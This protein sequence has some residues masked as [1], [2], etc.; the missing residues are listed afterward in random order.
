MYIVHIHD[1]YVYMFIMHIYT[2]IYTYVIQKFAVYIFSLSLS[3]YT[4]I[5]MVPVVFETYILIYFDQISTLVAK[6]I[7]SQ[8]NDPLPILPLLLANTSTDHS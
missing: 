4:Y 3:I 6:V 8:M 1:K 7:V 5:N 2:Y